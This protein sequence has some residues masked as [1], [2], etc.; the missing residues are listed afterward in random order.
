MNRSTNMNGGTATPVV[1]GSGVR[2]HLAT[3]VC[4]IQCIHVGRIGDAKQL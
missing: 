2:A 1:C 4:L 3:A